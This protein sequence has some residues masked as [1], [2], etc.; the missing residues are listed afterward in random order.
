MKNYILN[1]FMAFAI[2]APLAIP[3]GF[4]GCSDSKTAKMSHSA[5]AETQDSLVVELRG[6]TGKTVFDITQEK[7]CINYK[8]MPGGIFVKAIDSIESNGNFAWVYS[9]NGIM[10]Q[11]ASD[12]YITNDTDEIIWHFRKF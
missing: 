6:Q 5:S 2:I 4:L 1:F 12:K 9:V 8:K 7:Y 3:S 11:V 10:A